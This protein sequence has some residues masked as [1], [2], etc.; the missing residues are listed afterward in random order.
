MTNV[1]P[2]VGNNKMMLVCLNVGRNIK[3]HYGFVGNRNKFVINS[4]M[5]VDLF[6]M[7]SEPLSDDSI[8]VDTTLSEGFERLSKLFDNNV[9]E[10]NRSIV[11]PTNGILRYGT[12]G[13]GNRTF[14]IDPVKLDEKPVVY[15]GSDVELFI[16][17]N[18]VIKQ[19]QVILSGD[20]DLT[21]YAEILGSNRFFNYFIETVQEIYGSHGVNVNSKH[22]EMVL[23]LMINT[24]SMFDVSDSDNEIKEGNN[25][26]DIVRTNGGINGSNGEQ[27]LTVRKVDSITDVCVNQGSILSAISFQGAI[28]VAIRAIMLGNRFDVTGIKDKIMLGKVPP[29]GTGMFINKI[30]RNKP[31]VC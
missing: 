28:K 11:C 31:P 4:N 24:V 21:S 22:I 12:D 1:I 3:L 16:K 15:S 26:H 8:E 19:G 20:K 7:F 17:N 29:V 5:N 2:N 10:D 27:I 6:G 18:N 9:A 13:N 23:R 30:N 14:V 25:T